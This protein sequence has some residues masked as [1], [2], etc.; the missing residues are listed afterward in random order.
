MLDFKVFI[1]F[2]CIEE[3]YADFNGVCIEMN[4]S[5]HLAEIEGVVFKILHAA[6]ENNLKK[7]VAFVEGV[8]INGFNL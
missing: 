4:D 5:G 8:G 7:I 2:A 1:A 3:H 6:V